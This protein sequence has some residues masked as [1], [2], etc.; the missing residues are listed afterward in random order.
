MKPIYKAWL[1]QIEITNACHLSCSHCTRAVSHV[2]KPYFA[3]L[4]FVE[5]ALISLEGWKRGVGCI[6]GEPT[7]H[8]EFPA[9]C[10]LYRKYFPKKQRGLFT[11]GGK[12]Y[13]EHKS[14][15]EETFGII[16]YN[17][18]Q[19]G[20]VHQPMMVASKDVI[21]DEKLRNSLI[22]KCW[23]QTIW[24]PSITPKGAFFC[25]VAGTFDILFNGPGGYPIEPGWWKKSVA[26]FQDQRERYCTSCSMPLPM[27]KLSIDL[28]YEYVSISNAKKLQDAGSP[29]ARDG[30]LRVIDE[31]YT[32]EDIERMKR[33]PNLN[34]RPYAHTV[35]QKQHHWFKTMSKRLLVRG[36]FDELR[37]VLGIN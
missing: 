21:P 35:L 1:I 18:H 6:G 37:V 20:G 4:D 36:L 9:I 22:D 32:A 33:R 7:L 13:E 31:V 17:D 29:L 11:A 14:L 2:R 26:E 16:H 15:I 30:R 8:P 19:I 12:R 23:L 24:S 25:E 34:N 5:K 3:T 10:E 27:E 28:P